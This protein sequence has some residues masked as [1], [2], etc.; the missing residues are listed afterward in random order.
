ML[1]YL[2]TATKEQQ[3]AAYQYALDLLN[4]PLQ[5]EHIPHDSTHAHIMGHLEDKAETYEEMR[6]FQQFYED[7]FGTRIS[8]YG[9]FNTKG[10]CIGLMGFIVSLYRG[11]LCGWGPWL[12][13]KTDA[14]DDMFTYGKDVKKI[15][16]YAIRSSHYLY[17]GVAEGYLNT[18]QREMTTRGDGT[19]S[20]IRNVVNRYETVGQMV[21][22]RT[23]NS[24][25]VIRNQ[26]AVL[27]VGTA[28]PTTESAASDDDLDLLKR[29]YRIPEL[30]V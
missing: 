3:D 30:W 16:E 17:C 15:Y 24:D 6:A 23:K 5:R 19:D 1:I 8:E 20:F 14:Y 4:D 21:H 29:Y 2:P 27:L 11:H 13:R 28:T 12:A 18:R 26:R 7:K 10:E 22:T 9:S 25:G